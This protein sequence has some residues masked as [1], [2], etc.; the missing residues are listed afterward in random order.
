MG[1]EGGGD[2]VGKSPPKRSTR[3]GDLSDG[4]LSRPWTVHVECNW[5][6]S[7]WCRGLDGGFSRL[8]LCL[9]IFGCIVEVGIPLDLCLSIPGI[10]LLGLYTSNRGREIRRGCDKGRRLA[11]ASGHCRWSH[12]CMRRW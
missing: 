4:A 1:G 8:G 7:H 6:D 3:W 10:L 11:V 12:C 9:G 2:Q 5:F